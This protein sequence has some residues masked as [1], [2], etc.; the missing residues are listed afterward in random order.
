MI[1]NSFIKFK[2]IFAF[3][4]EKNDI[5]YRKKMFLENLDNKLLG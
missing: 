1:F 5:V 3:L 4:V 2:K